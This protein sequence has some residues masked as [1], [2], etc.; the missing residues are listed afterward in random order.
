MLPTKNEHMKVDDG[1]NFHQEKKTGK[2]DK[3]R[4]HSGRPA[5]PRNG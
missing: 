5:D 3:P 1:D 2:D 4:T